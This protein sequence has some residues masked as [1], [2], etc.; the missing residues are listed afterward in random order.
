MVAKSA[1]YESPRIYSL[2]RIQNLNTTETLFTLPSNF[3]PEAYFENAFGAILEDHIKPCTVKLKVTGNQQKYLRSLPLHHSQQEAE[4]VNDESVFSYFL[5]PTY[6]FKQEILLHGSDIEVLSP[7]WLRKDM[8]EIV[9]RM[10]C[11]Y[12]QNGE[13]I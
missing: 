13:T 5:S 11:L 3:D 9:Q 4:Q 12:Q 8:R 1:R 2:D 7:E 10:H 6:D